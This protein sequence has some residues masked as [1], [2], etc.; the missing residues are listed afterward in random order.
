MRVQSF[1][2]V[3]TDIMYTNDIIGEDDPLYFLNNLEMYD[4]TV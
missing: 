3:H 2:S 4:I 1:R